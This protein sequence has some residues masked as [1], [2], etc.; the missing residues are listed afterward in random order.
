MKVL[1]VNTSDH[2]GGAAIAACRLLKALRQQ[3]IDAK[4]LCRDKSLTTAKE[5]LIYMKGGWGGR[6]KF[7]LERLEIFIKNGFTRRGLFAV[8][9]ARMGND[10]TRL[11]AFKQADVIHLHW[12]NQA[13]LS[14]SDLHR[15]MQSG[16]PV[17][18][19]MHDMWNMTG[20][21]HQSGACDRWLKQCGKCPQLCKPSA[22][23][24]SYS[25]FQ[26]KQKFYEQHQ[27]TFVGCSQWL[28]SLAKQSPLL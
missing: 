23:D 27:L 5:G 15:I 20:V 28:T 1:L 18:W 19:T 9:T 4:M 6:L 17:V 3:G 26:R 8:D 25:T 16:K 13:M 2:A 21:C 22:H 14:L 10:I 11:Q 7:I 24:L 12:V